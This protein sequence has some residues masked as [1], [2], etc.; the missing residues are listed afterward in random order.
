MTAAYP[1][2]LRGALRSKR[3][4]QAPPFAQMAPRR[5]QGYMLN[6]GTVPPV[7]F[8]V[9]FR[10]TEAEAQVFRLWLETVVA[11]GALP[12]TMPLRTEFG[13]IEHTCQL[14]PD[15]LLPATEAGRTW[16]YS[17]TVMAGQQ[18][19]PSEYLALA[20]GLTTD[21]PDDLPGVLQASKQ[22]TR[23]ASFA[24]PQPMAGYSE[25]EVTGRDRPVQW[26]VEWAM[27]PQQA[28]LF[29]VWFV[30]VLDR[31]RAA[32]RMPIRTEFGLLWHACR[33]L[34]DGLLSASQDGEVWRYSASI[35][36]RA[37]LIP[38]DMLAAA[39]LIIALPDW[40]AWAD[41]LDITITATMPEA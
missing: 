2:H 3:R 23:E 37:E 16:G 26:D 4:R 9:E 1:A 31:G 13:L 14:L 22:R 17:A 40:P 11:S 27:Q 20:T 8:D 24:V 6:T 5:G 7:F 29:M 30:E 35:T 19:I 10:F 36:A 33:F 12:F 41:L 32:F 34:P 18:V 21:Y 38:A 25:A 28:Q 15:S 39:P